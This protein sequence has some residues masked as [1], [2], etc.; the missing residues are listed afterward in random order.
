MLICVLEDD[1]DGGRWITG[2][3]SE[4][5]RPVMRLLLRLFRWKAIVSWTR[6]EAKDTEKT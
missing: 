2:G 4:S 3:K 1:H 5:G 6:V